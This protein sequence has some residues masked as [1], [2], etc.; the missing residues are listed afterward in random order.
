VDYTAQISADSGETWTTIY[1]RQPSPSLDTSIV[2]MN[3]RLRVIGRTASGLYGNWASVD[4]NSP[5]SITLTGDYVTIEIGED[6]FAPDLQR[7]FNWNPLTRSFSLAAVEA[8]AGAQNIVMKS[9]SM[10]KASLGRTTASLEN[11]QQVVVDGDTALSQQITALTAYVDTEVTAAILD[12]Q[13][14]RAT[15]DDAV[16]QSVLDLQVVVDGNYAEATSTFTTYGNKFGQLAAQYTLSLDVNGYISSMR[17][18]NSVDQAAGTPTSELVFLV[19]NIY[20]G[21]PGYGN[22][23]IVAPVNTPTLGA[24]LGI[25]GSIIAT[26]SVIA[27][28]LS[29]STLSAIS[30]N[31][32]TMTAGNI[33]IVGATGA[34]SF[35]E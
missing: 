5:D 23:K 31:F 4:L 20:F 9:H 15:A 24:I 29:V 6:M 34:L 2:P 22:R 26:G 7:D 14:A 28:H 1:D 25:D 18:T 17:L 21:K 16:A 3:I 30:G 27:S 10:L 11:L 19:D 13:T 35:S 8:Q 32:G 12:E 33:D